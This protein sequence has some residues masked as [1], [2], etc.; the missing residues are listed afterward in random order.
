M[1][2]PLQAPDTETVDEAEREAEYEKAM[3]KALRL[4]AVRSRSR[5]ELADRLMR[6]GFEEMTVQA[7]DVRLGELGLL[8][9]AE[10]A[11]EVCRSRR[12]AGWS[13]RR[14]S[15]DLKSKGVPAELGLEAL[16]D[17]ESNDPGDGERARVLAL[18]KARTCRGVAPQKA[19]QRVVRHLYSKGYDPELA[20][21]AA[22]AAFSELETAG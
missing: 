15:Y 9:D 6:A 10:F 17:L 1:S 22:R 20:W 13:L 4:L 12:A 18:A 21:E 16:N 19:L 2:S 14:I 3:Q 5:R 8:N 11:A 7:V